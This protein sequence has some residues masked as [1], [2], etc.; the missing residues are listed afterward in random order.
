MSKIISINMSKIIRI[1]MSTPIL[2]MQ[3][4]NLIVIHIYNSERF[5]M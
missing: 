1:N 3:L 2:S 4:S 5:N